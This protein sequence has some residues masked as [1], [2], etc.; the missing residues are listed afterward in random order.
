MPGFQI[1][2]TPSLS[3]LPTAGSKRELEPLDIESDASSNTTAQ[4]TFF[5]TLRRQKFD[6]AATVVNP[7]GIVLFL[8]F[9]VATLTLAVD[10]LWCVVIRTRIPPQTTSFLDDAKDA[11]ASKPCFPNPFPQPA[12]SSVGPSL[13][14]MLYGIQIRRRHSPSS[15]CTISG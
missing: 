3:L 13:G 5:P 7:V 8:K 9:P 15:S 12:S 4:Y 10:L 6:V 2:T 14:N 11:S 1:S